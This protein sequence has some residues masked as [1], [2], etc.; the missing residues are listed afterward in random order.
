MDMHK[1]ANPARFNKLAD[2]ILPWSLGLMALAFGTGLYLSLFASPADYQQGEMVRMM[3]IHVPNAVLAQG[4]YVF[5]A[6]A[7]AVSLIWKHPLADLSAKAAAPIGAVFTVLAL[8]TGAIWGKPT[9]GAWWVWDARL[10]SVLIL[11]FLYFGYMAI[12]QAMENETRAAKAAA[13]LALVGAINIPIIKF[14]VEWW[15][16]LHQGASILRLDGPA[17][18]PDMLWPLF[19]MMAGLVAYF[20][21]VLLWRIKAEMAARKVQNLRYSRAAG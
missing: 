9:W 19:T 2:A 12:W 3:Y 7:S 13:I 18:H 21:T 11:L 1:Y 17:I 4:V 15:N 14:S 10:T 20:V 6:L 16:T 8:V 5:I